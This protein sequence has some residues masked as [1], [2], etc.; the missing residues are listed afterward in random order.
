MFYHSETL[1]FYILAPRIFPI[2]YNIAKPFLS[3]Y[4]KKKIIV[5]SGKFH[6]MNVSFIKVSH[7]YSYKDR[8]TQHISEQTVE[9]A[10]LPKSL[11]NMSYPS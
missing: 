7:R 10:K 2:I 9:L 6:Q 4:T 1:F 11:Q 3:E 8:P 5:L